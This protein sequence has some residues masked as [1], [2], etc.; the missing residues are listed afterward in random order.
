MKK[1][2]VPFFITLVLGL[3]TAGGFS[4]WRNLTSAPP[5][6][7]FSPTGGG[8]YRL[9]SSIGTSD[10]SI[11]LSSF[12]EPVSNI[13]Y[14]MSYLNSDIQYATLD[15]QTSKPEFVS[16]TSI[17]QNSD[18]TA[19]LT[20]VT[21]G[22]TRTP[23]GSACTSSTTLAQSHAAQSIFILSDSPCFFY[24]YLPARTLATSSAILIFSSTTPPRLD[25]PAAQSTGTY[26]ATTS[27]FA[28]ISYVNAIAI[29]GASNATESV[30]GLVE[31]GTAFEAASSTSLGGTGASLI[32]QTANATDTPQRG[33]A[34]GYGSTAGA[35][36]SVIA[37]LTGKIRQSFLNLVEAWSFTDLTSASSTFTGK[38]AL[39]ANNIST[40]PFIA[41]GLPYTWP[42]TRGASSTVLAENGSGGLIWQQPGIIQC[43][44]IANS[45]TSNSASTTLATCV[46]PANTL[47]TTNT[48]LKGTATWDMDIGTGSCQSHVSWGNGTATDTP[49]AI[50]FNTAGTM[51]FTIAPTSTSKALGTGVSVTGGNLAQLSGNT[52]SNPTIISVRRYASTSIAVQSYISFNTLALAGGPCTLNDYTVRV[53]RQ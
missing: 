48:I 35:G 37:Q 53:F 36:C 41:N 45:G 33:C 4:T 9:L 6:G 20:G 51:S 39:Q 50:L 15:P 34:S 27:E 47:N 26:I 38:F 29:S 10:T 11:S 22:L 3:L 18:G 25:Q 31:L 12:K 24:E 42:S 52:I 23:A 1:F 46:I 40:S 5:A 14:T 13:K 19:Q 7:A 17:T 8:T 49:I 43:S 28:S 2:F 44:V 32:M 21:R 16:F 30:K